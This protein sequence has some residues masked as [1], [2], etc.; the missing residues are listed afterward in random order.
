MEEF[1]EYDIQGGGGTES[2]CVFDYM[3]EEGI[4]PKKHP[5]LQ[6]VILGVVGAMKTIVTLYLLYMVQV[7][8]VRAPS[9]L[10]G[11]TVTIQEKMINPNCFK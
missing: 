3:K 7:M 1:L 9:T 2:D 5:R 10:F 8:V 6:T 11:I 4:V